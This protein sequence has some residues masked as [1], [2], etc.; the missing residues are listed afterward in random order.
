VVE[1]VVV[2]AEQIDA[3]I[4]CF[5]EFI[6]E[7]GVQTNRY[8]LYDFGDDDEGTVQQREDVLVF[9]LVAVLLHLLAHRVIERNDLPRQIVEINDGTLQRLDLHRVLAVHLGLE[10]QNELIHRDVY[11]L[12]YNYN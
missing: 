1:R 3:K 5:N 8:F 4:E 6:T 12:T 9:F 7:E 10:P 11:H 2:R